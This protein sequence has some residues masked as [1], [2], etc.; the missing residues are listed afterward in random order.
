MIYVAKRL[1]N[2]RVHSNQGIWWLLAISAGLI[3][4]TES[5]VIG[6]G[7][8]AVVA[9]VTASA[10]TPLATLVILLILA[11]MRTLILTEANTQL[12][13]DIGQLL[14]IGLFGFWLGTIIIRKHTI[15]S[16]LRW[17]PV[18]IPLLIFVVV[19]SISAF[20]SLSLG[21]WFN[22]WLKWIQILIL[23][24]TIVSFVRGEQWI[25]LIFGMIV[26]GTSNALIG[27]YEFFGG[28]GALHLLINNRFFRA[29]GT[30]GQPNPFG[31]FMG[32]LAPLGIM[33]TIGYTLR[34]FHKSR[35]G[36]RIVYTDFI[37]TIFFA[38]STGVIILGLVVSWS[39]GAWLGFIASSFIILIL[40][41]QKL[42]QSV[43]LAT[44]MITVGLLIATSSFIPTSIVSRIQSSTQEI[45][46]IHD[47]R[48][49]EITSENFAVLERL[50]HWQAALNMATNKPWLGVGIGNYEVAYDN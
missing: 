1:N 10:I 25:W 36:Q 50:A 33:L 19:I 12:P 43:L 9:T 48:G 13:I 4:T 39:R 17:S 27:I 37:S 3:L 16:S 7:L 24:T 38:L 31:A 21:V 32:M 28:S 35:T 49:V 23:V 45:F 47:V 20:G 34:L 42:W 2:T 6:A 5:V 30:F 8:F 11:P 41:P 44:G 29:F 22:E 15:M 26:A 14:L 18:Y 40:L 46:N